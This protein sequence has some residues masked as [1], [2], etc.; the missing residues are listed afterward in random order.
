M[1]DEGCPPTAKEGVD[2]L[3]SAVAAIGP[4]AS[5]ERRELV[6][7][8]VSDE[9]ALAGLLSVVLASTAM[10]VHIWARFEWPLAIGAILTLVLDVAVAV[11]F[12]ALTGL[13]EVSPDCWSA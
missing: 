2:R 4:S 10:R 3:R 13:A 8:K 9:L 12:F 7:P 6:G 11:G 5:V 1:T